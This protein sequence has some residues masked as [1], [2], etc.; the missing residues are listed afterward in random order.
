M[1]SVAAGANPERTN[2]W[3]LIGAA[4]L[5]ILTG[6]LLFFALANFGDSGSN[7]KSSSPSIVGDSKVLVAKQTIQPNTKITPDMFET[8]SVSK[9]SLVNGAV[10]DPAQLAD[11][12]VARTIVLKGEQLTTNRIGTVKGKADPGFR[13]TIPTGRRAVAVKVTE[14]TSVAGLL[15]PGD[16]VDVIATFKEKTGENETIRV[17][18]VLQ[19]IEVLAFAQKSLEALPSLNASG[20]PIATDSSAGSLGERP[21]D[22]SPNKSAGTATLSLSPEE[23]QQIV[24]SEAKGD[25]TL[26]LRAPADAETPDIPNTRLDNNGFVL[27]ARP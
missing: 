1:S 9:A 23:V 26:A 20:T 6:V 25:L 22:L 21:K 7:S 19:N 10:T 24:A 14:E 11:Q 3:L 12:P 18:T 13:D 27:P 15:V 5:A 2:R 4:A 8:V 16:R 17:E